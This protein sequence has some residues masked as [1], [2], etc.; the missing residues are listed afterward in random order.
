[1]GL[2][3]GFALDAIDLDAR[4]TG[5]GLP[6]LLPPKIPDI[7]VVIATKPNPYACND[8]L[9]A[10]VTGIAPDTKLNYQWYLNNASIKN[11]TDSVLTVTQSGKYFLMVEEANGCRSAKSNELDFVVKTVPLLAP[12][13][14][15]VSPICVGDLAPTLSATGGTIKWYEDKLLTKFLAQGATFTPKINTNSAQKYTFWATQSNGNNCVSPADS[16]EMVVNAKPVIS[17]PLHKIPYCLTAND[18]SGIKLTSNESVTYQWIFN[19]TVVSTQNPLPPTQYGH[20]SV[21]ATN[22]NG[23]I[24]KDSADVFEACFQ[25]HIP[26]IFTPS[27]KIPR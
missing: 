22:K 1:M 21:I 9:E 26:D 25:I 3:C 11:A 27:T 14:N 20:Y 24:A 19:K 7:K 2:S 4:K 16:V 12:K 10:N 15:A 5:W 13:I 17:L 6:S 23:C 8:I 18:N